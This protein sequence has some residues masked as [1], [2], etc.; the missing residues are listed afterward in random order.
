MS[1]PTLS[2]SPAAN[3]TEV[4]DMFWHA[5]IILNGNLDWRNDI[6]LG[7]ARDYSYTSKNIKPNKIKWSCSYGH[8][9]SPLSG[10]GPISWH[11]LRKKHIDLNSADILWQD[12]YGNHWDTDM[13]LMYPGHLT[14]TTGTDGYGSVA[15]PLKTPKCNDDAYDFI[16]SA[17]SAYYDTSLGARLSASEDVIGIIASVNVESGGSTHTGMNLK[18]YDDDGVYTFYLYDASIGT[19]SYTINYVLFVR[20]S[21]NL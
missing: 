21:S 13:F 14:I 20:C 3:A 17:T 16:N 7:T 6:D 8:D 15:L 1:L 5:T 10:S 9:H 4:W 2:L 18:V 19:S 12:Y 11:G